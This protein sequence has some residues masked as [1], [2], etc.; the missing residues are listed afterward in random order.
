ML[1][2]YGLTEGGGVVAFSHLDDPERE[3]TETGGRPF[4]GMEVRIADP[5]TDEE[6]PAGEVGADPRP[7]ARASSTATTATRSARPR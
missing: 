1:T 4:E 3:R 6:L 7:R 5:E 2:S